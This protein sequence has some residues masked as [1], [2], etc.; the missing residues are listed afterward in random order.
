[1][2][3]SSIQLITKP[4][5]LLIA[6]DDLD[7]QLLIEN[8][9]EENK[10]IG[11]HLFFKNGEELLN[12]LKKQPPEEPTIIILDLNMPKKNGWET[13]T[14]IKQSNHLKHIP[15]LFL[16]TSNS[17]RD[18]IKSYQL[19]GNTFFTKPTHFGELTDIVKSIKE[20][21]STKAVF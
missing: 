17:D 16:T 4:I 15:V 6:D 1:M 18:I 14:E 10:W 13:L 8:A 2:T 19:G 11:D 5:R 12:H 9:L 21:W 3:D 7:D 20:Y